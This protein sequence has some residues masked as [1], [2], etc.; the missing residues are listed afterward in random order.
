MLSYSAHIS[1]GQNA[2]KNLSD[3]SGRE[4]HNARLYENYKK[5]KT[6]NGLENNIDFSENEF[7]IG[8]KNLVD[9]I[10]KIYKAEFS[11]A[12]EEYNSRQKRQDRRID[13]YLEHISNSKDQQVATEMII[14][15]GDMDFWKSVD[16]N[17]K[18]K[19]KRV[20]QGQ[21]DYLREKYSDFK[22]AQAVI[23]YDESSPHLHIIGVP[24]GKGI[25][26]GMAKKVKKSAI[27]NRN[28]LRDMQSN[29]R[30]KAIF[31]FRAVYGQEFEFKDKEKGR[32][33]DFHK[34]RYTYLSEEK[35]E[36]LGLI[37]EFKKLVQDFEDKELKIEEE[38]I[39][40]I[41]NFADE[42]IYDY[43][44][45]ENYSFITSL[46]NIDSAIKD[47]NSFK[48]GVKPYFYKDSF[49]FFKKKEYTGDF[50]KATNFD[51]DISTI[52]SLYKSV[53]NI[54]FQLR[55]TFVSEFRRFDAEKR[56][57]NA[58]NRELF[59]S[60]TEN[61]TQKMERTFE[62]ERKDPEIKRN[63]GKSR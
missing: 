3:L 46:E 37:S 7:L 24:I 63:K 16:F 58:R 26:K 47:L 41:D 50:D 13:D 19:I 56:E 57:R 23:H 40:K 49:L 22:I 53:E 4:K 31:D 42:K 10:K 1:N 32:N 28:S 27:F 39:Q 38:Y 12:L 21:L 43:R 18:K 44:G 35:K 55:N 29:M 20:F 17:D 36:I 11:A 15:V 9:N 62:P 8:D 52:R 54:E 14:Q 45:I 6:D 60:K 30:D 2:I 33:Q 5:R 51:I 59:K 34:D 48:S 61:L 25:K